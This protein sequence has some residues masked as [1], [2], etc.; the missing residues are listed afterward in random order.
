MDTELLVGVT[1]HISRN[2][3]DQENN[4]DYIERTLRD[5]GVGQ[6]KHVLADQ[7]VD[8]EECERR[9]KAIE[10][11]VQPGGGTYRPLERFDN[12]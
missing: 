12:R 5:R 9:I 6:F 8:I 10:S 7:A 11:I 3:A 4:F 2:P 1:I